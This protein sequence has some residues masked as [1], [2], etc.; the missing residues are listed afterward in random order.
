MKA[1]FW[2]QRWQQ[3]QIGFHQ[4]EINTHLQAFWDRLDLPAGC[5]VFVPLCGKSRDLLWLRSRGHRVLG[6]ELSPIATRAFFDENRLEPVTHTPAG[7]FERF[8][9]DGITI[10]CGDFFRLTADRLEGVCGVYDRASLVALPP[11]M[12]PDYARHLGAILPPDACLL[13]VT[14]EY[15]QQQMQ[16]PPFSVGEAEVRQLFGDR[17][18]IEPLYRQEILDENP[19]FRD[20]G[21][22]A[23]E[24]KVY[25]LSPP[26]A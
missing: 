7:P 3:N 5:P 12:R 17:F 6:V 18:L 25:R 8:E 16:G 2:H 20:K 9:M 15:P 10:L 13:L 4:R 24:E 26:P 23:L 21:L 22:T 14:M 19:R 11:P 1:D